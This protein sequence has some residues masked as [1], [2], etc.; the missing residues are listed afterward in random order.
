MNISHVK[1]QGLGRLEPETT[2][3]ADFLDHFHSLQ[4]LLVERVLFL[5]KVVCNQVSRPSM[6]VFNE[7]FI[8]KRT[9]GIPVGL[10]GVSRHRLSG[11]EHFVTIWA[12][13]CPD[14]PSFRRS[15]FLFIQSFVFLDFDNYR[16]DVVQF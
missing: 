7:A 5:L 13:K 6:G 4:D 8:T 10:L 12:G 15:L 1:L 11:G 2:Q 9:L 14:F 3:L 16:C